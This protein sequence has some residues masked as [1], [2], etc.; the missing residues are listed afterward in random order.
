MSKTETRNAEEL[1]GKLTDKQ[2]ETLD[3]LLHH[4]T[5][6][7][8]ARD[9]EIS[10]HTVEQRLRGAK[11]RLGVSRRSDLA[12]AY[13][14]LLLVCEETVYQ[15]SDVVIPALKLSN[16]RETT[17]SLDLFVTKQDTVSLSSVND[18]IE[19]VHLAPAI[20]EGR[21]GTWVRIGAVFAIAAAIII[22]VI[23]GMA[24]FE[25]LSRLLS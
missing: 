16:E 8:I 1:L 19:Y 13:R 21:S 11:R 5:S 15:E 10:P 14:H 23:G 6:K 18:S 12:T 22:L 17:A 25:Q 3:L 7:E 20:F 9:L 2:R 24:M 4:K